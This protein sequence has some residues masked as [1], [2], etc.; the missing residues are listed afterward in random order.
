[1]DLEYVP[2]LKT[3]RDIYRLP[4]GMERFR[5]Y[6]DALIDKDADDI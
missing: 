3:Q 6:L 2:L 1:M 4:R 5:E